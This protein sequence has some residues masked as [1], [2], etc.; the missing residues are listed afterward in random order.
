[1]VS[2]DCQLFY[3]TIY[4]ALSKT[5]PQQNSPS[6]CTVSQLTC[7]DQGRITSIDYHKTP[8]I[9]GK[10][11]PEIGQLTEL[12]KLLL[13]Q[14]NLHGTLPASI[15]NLTK[16]TQLALG[17]NSFEGPIPPEYGNLQV[18]EQLYFDE[19]SLNGTVPDSLGHIPTLVILFVQ[20]NPNIVGP[21]PPSL[22]DLNMSTHPQFSYDKSV[23]ST[24]GSTLSSV[25]VSPTSSASVQILSS[26]QNSNAILWVIIGIAISIVCIIGVVL[27]R[28]KKT[29]F[30]QLEHLDS[31][32]TAIDRQES[33]VI[34]TPI[35]PFSEL[36]YSKVP[37]DLQ[38]L[39][40]HQSRTYSSLS[41]PI[42]TT[43]TMQVILDSFLTDEIIK[44][45]PPLL[46]DQIYDP[47][48]MN[49]PREGLSDRKEE[50]G[51]TRNQPPI[52]LERESADQ[53]PLLQ[54][55]QIHPPIIQQPKASHESLQPPDFHQTPSV[56][57]VIPPEIGQLSQLTVIHLYQNN[58]HG[59]LPSSISNLKS[60]TDL[61]LGGNSLEGSIPP[62]YG[63]L[64]QIQVMYFD[65]NKLTGT[66]PDSLGKIPT[67]TT[68]SVQNNLLTGPL[69]ASLQ[70]LNMNT[71]PQFNC[72]SSLRTSP[73]G[74]SNNLAPSQTAIVGDPGVS[75]NSGLIIGVTIGIVI[76]LVVA[77]GLFLYFKKSNGKGK[78]ERS[79]SQATTVQ[80]NESPVI[81][82]PVQSSNPLMYEPSE[83]SDAQK[84][85]PDEGFDD[86]IEK[87]NRNSRINP[88]MR[89][90]EDARMSKN[91]DYKYQ[92]VAIQPDY[93][94]SSNEQFNPFGYQRSSN[95]QFNQPDYQEKRKE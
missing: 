23:L 47:Y 45:Q 44:A 29:K 61:S 22:K 87:I 37:K 66:V 85:L 43:P 17:G 88:Y 50:N 64:N 46:Y 51:T 70:N 31:Q 80:R 11:T 14:N 52:I 34:V 18:L 13:Y 35:E 79:D 62:E 93:R 5:D 21:L 39:T 77:V 38:V 36:E 33:P 91:F 84:Y 59:N 32:S 30:I 71:K 54:S 20:N 56:N 16:L 24:N 10:I 8:T 2:L 75:S 28:L 72:D 73:T 19:N 86:H 55:D 26:N 92:Q 12:T 67:L 42:E 1:M 89:N 63:N 58:L 49:Q 60:L 6:C 81:V 9:S 76:C 95:E 15:S 53:P 41:T 7:D 68:L 83:I 25:S 78:L 57:G 40:K 82:T 94:R 74:T 4:P 27:F 48:L 90:V 65:E 69:P 3:S